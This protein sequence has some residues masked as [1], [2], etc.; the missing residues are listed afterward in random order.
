MAR[1]MTRAEPAVSAACTQPGPHGLIGIQEWATVAGGASNTMTAHRPLSNPAAAPCKRSRYRV[2][3]V[4]KPSR[5][6]KSA[7]AKSGS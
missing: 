5:A 1:P 3:M 2:L 4:S 6:T 7:T